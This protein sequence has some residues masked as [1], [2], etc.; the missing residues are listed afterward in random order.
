MTDLINNPP[1]YNSLEAACPNCGENIECI[2]ITSKMDFVIGNAVKY[3]W[4]YKH[5]NGLQDLLKAKWYINYEIARLE[6][7]EAERQANE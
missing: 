2:E 7:I 1:H 3:L 5:K 6:R 4:R